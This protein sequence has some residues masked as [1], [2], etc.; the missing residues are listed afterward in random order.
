MT[1]ITSV[2]ARTMVAMGTLAA[3][4][5]TVFVWVENHLVK[6]TVNRARVSVMKN[7]NARQT[8]TL[9]PAVKRLQQPQPPLH[10]QQELQLLTS[11]QLKQLQAL[12]WTVLMFV[13]ARVTAAL[14]TLAAPTTTVLVLG[15]IH[16][17]KATVKKGRV[18]VGVMTNRNARKTVRNQHAVKSLIDRKKL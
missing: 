18:G 4:T 1:V 9:Q 11:L 7:R 14:L 5:T 13:M 16:M 12:L 17:E 8:V 10:H 15:G 2:L 6:R 3:L